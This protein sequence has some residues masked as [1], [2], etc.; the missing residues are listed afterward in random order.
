M[1]ICKLVLLCLRISYFKIIVYQ[2]VLANFNRDMYG[3]Y[4]FTPRELTNWCLSLLRYNLSDFKDNTSVEPLLEIWAYEA[5]RLFQ[6][7]LV[8]NEAR[9]QFDNI[10]STVLQEDWRT[11]V[12]LKGK[13]F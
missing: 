4:L 7:R 5:C 13:N 3:H 8:D 1:S 11:S 6:D 12:K 9:Q 2:K 10:L